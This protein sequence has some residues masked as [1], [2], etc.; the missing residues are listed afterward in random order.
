ML[1]FKIIIPILI[2]LQNCFT[3]AFSNIRN[4]D[5]LVIQDPYIPQCG[6][7]ISDKEQLIVNWYLADPYQFAYINKHGNYGVTGIDIELI[8]AV[9]NK[10]GVNVKYVNSSWDK[11]ILNI[12]NGKS[13]IIAGASYTDERTTL[14]NFSTPYRLEEISLFVLKAG[15]KQINFNNT[16]EFLAQIRLLNFRLG[17]IKGFIYGDTKISAYLNDASNNDIIIKY[18]NNS[19]LLQALMRREIEG[20]ITEKIT[21]L[22]L[23]LD[24]TNEPIQEISTGIKTPLHFIF[25]KKT[26]SN[27]LVERFNNAIKEAINSVDY[28]KLVKRHLYCVLMTK[29]MGLTWC[30]IIGVMG[31][32]AFAI[33]GVII[34]AQKNATLFLTFL[35][36]I[37]PSIIGCVSLDLT[38]NHVYNAPL[39]LTP[40]YAYPVLI[41]VLIGFS[42][43]KLFD[44]YNNHLYEDSFL[45]K[46]LNNALIIS[47]S[48]GQAVFTVIGVIIII[49]EKIE[50]LEFWGPCLAFLVS[51]IGVGVRNLIYNYGENNK[52]SIFKEI[53]FE[54]SILWGVIFIMLL[55]MYAYNPTFNTIKY[56][57]IMV[58]AGGGVSKLLV[59][60]YNIPNLTF[61]TETPEV[62]KDV[63]LDNKS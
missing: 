63:T 7:E 50:P 8:N 42:T 32:I 45:N 30:Y 3:F 57:I 21:G 23:I 29:S 36:A 61:R 1:V 37:L 60:Y 48:I 58:I 49:I 44:Y 16:N 6:E 22:A 9:S 59:Y 53:N 19:E 52:K 24:G 38:I 26:V 55:D 15:K 17:I 10:V 46:V 11:S 41:T 5:L 33:S 62:H 28:K 39:I 47:D 35:L 4:N 40:T 51:S 27:D 20:F 34:A 14:V 31:T 43:L 18:E 25:S 54:I 13:D 12:Q 2:I 56:T